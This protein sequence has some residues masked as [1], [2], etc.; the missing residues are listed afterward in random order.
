MWS[1]GIPGRYPELVETLARVGYAAK[2]FVYALIGWLA[3]RAAW[4]WSQPLGPDKALG[5]LQ[6]P[7]LLAIGFGL[8]AFSLWRF[9]QTFM[10]AD[11][12]GKSWK[13]LVYRAGYAL[14]GLFYLHLGKEALELYF[15]RP[16][17]DP[18]KEEL[19]DRLLHAP[20]GEWL[21]AACGALIIVVGIAQGVKAFSSKFLDRLDLSQL[22]RSG[23][24][25]TSRLAVLGLVAR[26]IVFGFVGFTVIQA[27]TTLNPGEYTAPEELFR[28]FRK[29]PYGRAL[30]G[31]IAAGFISYGAFMFVS[32]RF[33][34]VS[35]PHL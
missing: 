14:S 4:S 7:L 26:G 29:L 15:E 1:R 12:R 28:W 23:R 21:V 3:L 35:V 5:I 13:G 31:S 22:S 20:A 6:H 33:R 16:E 11:R 18:S 10:D 8:L 27:A 19:L 34:R 9:V 17:P 30:L 24:R 2:G 25:W 32:A